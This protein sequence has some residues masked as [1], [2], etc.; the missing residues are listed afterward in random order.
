MN[1]PND[2]ALAALRDIH[3]PEAV[4]L[5]PPAPGW[6]LLIVVLLISCLGIGVFLRL[7]RRSL[8]RAALLELDGV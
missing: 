2:D 5:W 8:K 4:A 6:W 7:R 1:T 3:L